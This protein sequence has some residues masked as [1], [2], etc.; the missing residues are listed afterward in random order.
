MI[1]QIGDV[2]LR[3]LRTVSNVS[4]GVTAELAPKCSCLFVVVGKVG[5]NDYRLKDRNTGK[6]AG[7]AHAFQL[8]NFCKE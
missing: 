4:K 7:L 8:L 2:V 1:F 6:S 3:S 5:V